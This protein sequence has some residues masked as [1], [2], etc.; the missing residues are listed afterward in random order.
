M[1]QITVL[2]EFAQEENRVMVRAAWSGKSERLEPLAPGNQQ[3]Y[4][5]VFDGV[6][7]KSPV[8]FTGVSK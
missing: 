4:V 1:K 7:M 3:N 6:P 2:L 8:G 5:V